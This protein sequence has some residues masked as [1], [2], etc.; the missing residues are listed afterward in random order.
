MRGRALGESSGTDR[1]PEGALGRCAE[2]VRKAPGAAMRATL[3]N[4]RGMA[5]E[6]YFWRQ[7]DD[8]GFGA[9][10]WGSARKAAETLEGL[11]E[12]A[13]R[14]RWVLQGPFGAHTG[15][16]RVSG[17]LRGGCAWGPEEGPPARPFGNPEGTGR[18]SE[19]SFCQG[20]GGRL[21]TGA[22]LLPWARPPKPALR[23]IGRAH[24]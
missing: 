5:S 3:W 2:L 1:G 16:G 17:A 20:P 23:K 7:E 19:R 8:G 24:V 6:D 15:L 10:E 22:G 14:E 13:P 11:G 4:G 12:A 9:K 18:I 21:G